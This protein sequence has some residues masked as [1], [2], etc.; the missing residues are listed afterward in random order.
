MNVPTLVQEFLKSESESEVAQSCPTLCDPMDG[1]LPGSTV[2][3]IFQARILEWA[4]I[5]F[6]R[7]SSQP[8]DHTWV[9]CIADRCFT[10]WAIREAPTTVSP[11]VNK[12]EGTQLHLSTE[13]WIK[14]VLSMAPPIRTRPSFPLSQSFP[15]GSF[16]K[17]LILLHQRADRRETTVTEN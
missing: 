8:R 4:A 15:S 7:G 9:S 2:H 3:G 16:H 14:N 10:I 6:S 13:N 1:S 17:P 11:Q 12:R 5:S